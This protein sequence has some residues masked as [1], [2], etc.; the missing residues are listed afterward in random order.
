MKLFAFALLSVLLA[1]AT[2]TKPATPPTHVDHPDP[3]S[4]VSFKWAPH[5]APTT[6]AEE[7]EF[8][9]DLKGKQLS[10]AALGAIACGAVQSANQELKDLV[11]DKALH[12]FYDNV[13]KRLVLKTNVIADINK[14]LL[15]L[16]LATQFGRLDAS[17]HVYVAE[18]IDESSDS[19]KT[20]ITH[21]NTLAVALE[22][23]EKA[24]SLTDDTKNSEFRHLILEV[25]SNIRSH[26]K[27]CFKEAKTA[28][29]MALE[30]S[31]IMQT[32]AY[33]LES[34]DGEYKN[35]DKVPINLVSGAAIPIKAMVEQDVA[36]LVEKGAQSIRVFDVCISNAGNA[37]ND[38]FLAAAK[39]ALNGAG[40]GELAGAA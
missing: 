8:S 14:G 36:Q 25:F 17:F 32:F 24:K 12:I 3:I 38:G 30:T 20:K 10:S 16:E 2:A 19:M 15:V 23:S 33:L 37:M 31:S 26:V 1:V 7:K 6:G 5:T 40:L 35:N 18:L 39:K 11:S 22:G 21:D 13:A 29:K 27:L 34:T 9:T 28:V 4:K